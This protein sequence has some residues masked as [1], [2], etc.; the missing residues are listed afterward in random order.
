MLKVLKIKHLLD[1][2]KALKIKGFKLC[3]KLA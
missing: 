3:L 2:G 1:V